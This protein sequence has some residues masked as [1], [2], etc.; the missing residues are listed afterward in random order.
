M[1]E[2]GVIIS[3]RG[4]FVNI[5]IERGEKCGEC[6][7]CFID[8]SGKMQVEARNDIGAKIGDRV[9][10]EIEPKR[11]VGHSFLIFVFPILMMI[12]G[13]FV[14]LQFRT[15]GDTGEGPGIVGA[16]TALLLSFGI[17]RIFDSVWKSRHDSAARVI[18]FTM[19]SI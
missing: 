3:A 11:V 16:F 18:D 13:Y 5:Q 19:K 7:A 14:A 17:L 1:R 8:T 4:A 10:V 9:E 6:S 15:I 12:A 2:S